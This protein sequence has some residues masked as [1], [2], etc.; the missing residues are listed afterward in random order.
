M[1]DKI[2]KMNEDF[3]DI[4]AD[5][6]SLNVGFQNNDVDVNGDK[7]NELVYKINKFIKNMNNMDGK[8][9]DIDINKQLKEFSVELNDLV[10]NFKKEPSHDSINQLQ[11]KFE[12]L[13]SEV[14]VREALNESKKHLLHVLSQSKSLYKLDFL[15]SVEENPDIKKSF[16]RRVGLNKDGNLRLDKIND[17]PLF[18][19][20]L[21]KITTDYNKNFLKEHQE[22]LEKYVGENVDPWEFFKTTG[23][24]KEINAVSKSLLDGVIPPHINFQLDD[25]Y[26][27][28]VVSGI[29]K[30]ELKTLASYAFKGASNAL[31]LINFPQS[32]IVKG[33]F[34]LCQKVGVKDVFSEKAKNLR[35]KYPE[36]KLF[37]FW[38]KVKANPILTAATV[39]IVGGV[40]AG[41][42]LYGNDEVFRA[43]VDNYADG[44]I[45]KANSILEGEVKFFTETSDVPAQE[46]ENI[47]NSEDSKNNINGESNNKDKLIKE[48]DLVD[49][50][51]SVNNLSE[52]F[53]DFNDHDL[54]E[55]QKALISDFNKTDMPLNNYW[56]VGGSQERLA[57]F[58]RIF[59]SNFDPNNIK[60]GDKIIFPEV[61]ESGKIIEGKFYSITVEPGDTMS[62]LYEEFR[63]GN[64]SVDKGDFELIN[65]NGK[66]SL[67]IKEDEYSGEKARAA[68]DD[69]VSLAYDEIKRSG[70][71]SN[72]PDL[73]FI[74]QGGHD[75]PAS[76]Y[77]NYRIERD[78]YSVQ[79]ANDLSGFMTNLSQNNHDYKGLKP[80]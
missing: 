77:A 7:N 8:L 49:L 43:A 58:N 35:E 24:E 56:G 69:F 70:V 11:V 63:T 57:E 2:E 47:I 17:E 68:Y 38:D 37:K 13:R 78:Y 26:K 52:R 53:S 10:K 15:E 5:L 6:R 41:C 45:A 65:D 19:N 51:G 50:E 9:F 66:D 33:M 76:Q 59:N 39:L 14:D 18:N 79:R 36:S 71:T 12:E 64:V 67:E 73:D 29:S 3:I 34:A 75:S 20:Y 21:L 31:M 16:L 32:L 42:L 54:T 1:N 23:S 44:V 80:N 40:S 55:S 25:A 27:R 28:G 74:M 62:E 30:E 60:V 22:W 61:S 72:N 46:T 48:G 4:L